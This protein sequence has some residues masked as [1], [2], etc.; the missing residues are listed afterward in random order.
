MHH[1]LLHKL[2]KKYGIS[3]K[4]LFYVKEYGPHSNVPRTIIKESIKILLLASIISAFGGFALENIKALF[5]SIIPL[6]V[7][8]PA[9]NDLIGDFG[10]I[11]SARFATMLHEGKIRG[12]W[13][14][15]PELKKLFMQVLIVAGIMAV[16]SASISVFAYSAPVYP[17]FIFNALKIF[18]VAIADVVI[19]AALLFLVAVFAGIYFFKKGEDPNN[20]LIP[21][22]TSI[23]DFGNMFLLA[24]LVVVVF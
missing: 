4:T 18:F 1:P 24:A 10:T 2:H 15:N 11:I 23:A 16:F 5:V 9:L 13:Q 6:I 12:A 17:I 20:F 21:I 3:R 14:K 22:T 8:L 7:L 19:L